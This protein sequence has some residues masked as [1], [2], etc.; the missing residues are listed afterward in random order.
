MQDSL[1]YI[2]NK[3][4]KWYGINGRDFSWRHSK[5]PYRIMIAEFMLHRTK[6]EQIVPVYKEFIKKYP[7]V[8]SLA[9]AE[10]NEIKKVT[11]HLGLH[12]R[13]QHFITSAVTVN[14]T[15]SVTL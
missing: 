4:F 6:A 3:L 13:A 14:F 15:P 5:D 7:D 11:E 2:R 1:R 9:S 8:K 10:L 12:W